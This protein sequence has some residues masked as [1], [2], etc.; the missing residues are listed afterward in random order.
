MSRHSYVL[1]VDDE[2]DIR[3]AVADMLAYCGHDAKVAGNGQEAFD[4]LHSSVAPCLILLDLMMPVM[5]GLEFNRLRRKDPSLAAIPV[6]VV[7]AYDRLLPKAEGIVSVVGK[8]ID[9]GVLLGV[10]DRYC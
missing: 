4:L 3:E 8:P 5:D 1:V 10:I 6:C 7:T 2:P 9:T